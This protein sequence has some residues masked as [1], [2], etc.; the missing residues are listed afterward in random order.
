MIDAHQHFWN[1]SPD[2]YGWINDKMPALRRDFLPADLEVDQGKL[3]FKGSIAVQ[4]RQSA[5]ENAWL[6]NLASANPKILGVVGWVDLCASDVA[7]QLHPL[8]ADPKFKGVR[9]AVQDEPDDQFMLRGDFLNGLEQVAALNLTYDLLL[10][11]RQLTAAIVVAKK[12]PKLRLVLDHCAKP[13]I[14][15]GQRTPWR[16]QI[17]ELATSPN[18]YCK[19]SGLVTEANWIHWRAEEFNPYLDVIFKAFGSKRLMFGSDWP[20]CTL[21]ASYVQVYGIVDAYLKNYSA[22]EREA[23]FG[24]T[25]A[26]FYGC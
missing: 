1:Y 9:H 6:L 11:P 2:Q 25:A 4:A 15:Q 20:V 19:V 14:G 18:V 10:Y 24:G 21:A 23:V 13:S 22:L 17:Q 8:R 3:G 7:A 26:E 5:Q 16:E 12:F